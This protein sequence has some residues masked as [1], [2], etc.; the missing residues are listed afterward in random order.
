MRRMTWWLA[1]AVAL[2]VAGCESNPQNASAYG[3]V[4]IRLTD[5]PPGSVPVE[6]ATVWISRVEIIPGSDS[7]S[8]SMNSSRFVV[9]D[10]PAV[11]DLLNLQ[12]GVSAL[13]GSDSI[14]VGSYDQLRLIVD[15]A[16]VT[17][18][19]GVTFSD[20]S[21]TK[22]LKVPSGMQTGIKVNFGGP[23]M[24]SPGHQLLMVDFDVS[25]SFVFT[26]RAS[27]P[28]GAIFKPVLHGTVTDV[29][30]SIAGTS[31]PASAH[32]ELFAIL[33]TDTV[34]TVAADTVTGTYKFWFLAPGTYTVADSAPGFAT[35]TQTVVLGP[36]Q[37]VT[38]VDFNLVGTGSIA[39]NSAPVAAHGKLFAIL[40]S[41]TVATVLADTT[42]G[43][44]KLLNLGPG[45]YTVADSAP[46]YKTATQSVTLTAGSQVTGVNFTLSQ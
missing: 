27:S 40:G 12:G 26:G 41:D 1:G 5:A 21:T 7:G 28:N 3:F 43:D 10:T 20:G 25:R 8:D 14:P 6:S 30:G 2:M 42:T 19:P 45:V 35:L 31:S 32:G 44:Y 4:A 24:V 38:G 23:I 33:G 36:G 17:I 15:S 29:A 13:L 9:S 22:S 46:G 18:G 37:N 39:G 11:F 34:G 16:R